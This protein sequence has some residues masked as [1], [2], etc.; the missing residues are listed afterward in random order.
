MVARSRNLISLC[1]ER[2]SAW[3]K[4]GAK[5]YEKCRPKHAKRSNCKVT[6]S[7]NHKDFPKH[8]SLHEALPGTKRY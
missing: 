2:N 5:R 7:S 8:E 1:S 4:F 3:Y 6:Q